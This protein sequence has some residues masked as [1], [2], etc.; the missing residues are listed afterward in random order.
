MY[1]KEVMYEFSFGAFFFG[2]I[3]LIFG[4]IG[5]IYYQKLADNL[6]S[7]VASYDKFRMWALIVCGI[8]IVVMLSLHTIPLNWLVNS[9]FRH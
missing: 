1:N 6:G 4:A 7:G 5:V 8:G 2:I 3:I 9:I